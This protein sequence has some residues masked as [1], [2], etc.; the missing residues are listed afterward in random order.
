M[1]I[2]IY[3]V[4]R[5]IRFAPQSII[6]AGTKAYVY[7]IT[8]FSMSGAYAHWVGSLDNP[9]HS[10]KGKKCSN[11][12][13]SLITLNNYCALTTRVCGL[14][15]PTNCLIKLRVCLTFGEWYH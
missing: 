8:R 12:T 5:L 10:T 9:S 4:I 3:I 7:L 6:W 11:R 13:G 14:V 2:K 15:H 1:A